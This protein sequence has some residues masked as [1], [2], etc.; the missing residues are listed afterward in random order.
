M[1]KLIE[2]ILRYTYDNIT[3]KLTVYF[4]I[5]ISFAIF[6]T[7]SG[8]IEKKDEMSAFDYLVITIKKTILPLL[9]LCSALSYTVIYGMSVYYFPENLQ[10]KYMDHINHSIISFFTDPFMYIYIIPI[11]LT[12]PFTRFV[13]LRYIKPRISAIFRHWRI[14]QTNTTLSDIRHEMETLKAKDYDPRPYFKDGAFFIGKNENEEPIYIS[15]EDFKKNHSKIPGASQKGKGVLLGLL[16]AQSVIKKFG[17]W[18]NDIKPDDFIYPI[19]VQTC[20]DYNLP[21][22]IIVDLTGEFEGLGYSPFINGTN[23][24]RKQRIVKAFRLQ[25]TGK[26]ADHYLSLNRSVL[27]KVFDYWDGS[28][29]HLKKLLNGEHPSFD[30]TTQLYVRENSINLRTRLDEWLQYK[31]VLAS[32]KNNFNVKDAL[33]NNRVVY[34]RGNMND[35]IIRAINIALYDEVI[36]VALKENLPNHT[37]I[38]WDEARFLITDLLADSLATLLSK[39]ISMAITFQARNDTK[40]LKDPTL[41]VDSIQNGIEVNTQQTFSYGAQDDESAKWISEQTG[42]IIVSTTKLESVETNSSGAEEWQ[43]KRMVGTDKQWLISENKMKALPARV[44]V[45]I[46]PNHLAE[47]F[48]TCWIPLKAPIAKLVPL[49][50]NTII[51]VESNSKNNIESKNEKITALQKQEISKK[52]KPKKTIDTTELEKAKAEARKRL[53]DIKKNT[54]NKS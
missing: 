10:K 50:E 27:Y 42:E 19:L 8:K 28:L 2:Q 25:D 17:T 52:I 44:G 21:M 31:T 26:T 32:G 20:K 16:L 51:D 41:N 43:G 14:K 22:P 33:L 38:A 1:Y 45:I 48:Y 23:L 18:F 39:H 53:E 3:P 40:N 11:M 29:P 34:V 12:L 46:R 13:I 36:Q 37:F 49:K 7:F 5:I 30:A 24:E 15:D 54:V 6:F 47:I 35:P 4:L 9:I